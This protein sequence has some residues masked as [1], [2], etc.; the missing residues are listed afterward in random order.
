MPVMETQCP[1]WTTAWQ[2]P[3]PARDL[4]RVLT[5]AKL[6]SRLRIPL[7]NSSDTSTFLYDC[8]SWKLTQAVRRKLKSTA[9]KI[10][11]TITWRTIADEARQ[12]L[13]G[14]CDARKRPALELTGPHSQNGRAPPDPTC[15]SI[16]RPTNP[17]IFLGDVS[18]LEI[19]AAINLAKERVEWKKNWF[20]RRC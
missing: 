16:M 12:P 3:G 4:K 7:W 10:L 1:R 19:Q 6:P 8:E 9:S 14:C 20:S 17:R 15:P 18:G 2:S 13:S 11:S 5:Y